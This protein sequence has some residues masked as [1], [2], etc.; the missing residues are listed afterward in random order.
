MEPA[1]HEPSTAEHAMRYQL[2][3]EIDQP[4]ERVIELFL[5]SDNLSKWQPSLV[6]FDHISGEPREV[7]AKSRQVHRMGKRETEMIETITAHDPPEH[8]SAT[9]EADGIWNLIE[10]RFQD[11]SEHKTHWTLDCEFRCSGFVIRLMT[12]FAPWMFKRQTSTFMH[13]FKEF[14]EQSTA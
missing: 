6:S 11:I 13:R 2:E 9:Y 7:G 10:N 14:A 8:F 3:L 1:T 4:R 12:I 5:D